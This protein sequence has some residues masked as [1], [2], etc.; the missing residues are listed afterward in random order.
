MTSFGE[1]RATLIRTA[2]AGE[3][4]TALCAL[5][6]SWLAERY[7]SEV[8]ECGLASNGEISQGVAL[9]AVGGYGRGELCPGS[10]IDLLLLHD[11][12]DTGSL[13]D[14]I[15]YPIWD[16]KL[17]LGHAVRSL[18]Q[19]LELAASDTDTATAIV[20]AR[21]LAGDESLTGRLISGVHTDWREHATQRLEA[22]Q[23]AV[24][25][26]HSRNG[27][28]AFLLE[29]DLKAGRGGLRD[30]HAIGWARLAGAELPAADTERLAD[31]YR[32]LLRVRTELHRT[33]GWRSDVLSAD[34]QDAV[35]ERLAFH[36]ADALMAEIAQAGR[37]VAFLSDQLWSSVTRRHVAHKGTVAPTTVSLD[38]ASPATFAGLSI[39]DGEVVIDGDPA[40]DTVL[41]LHAALH[42][43]RS[44]IPI[45]RSSLDKLAERQEW[46]ADPWP[47][48][49][50]DVLVDLLKCGHKAIS[51]IETLDYFDVWT[52]VLPE[53]APN[54]HRP[55][56]SR[57][58]RFTVDRHLL[59]A[60]AE[61]T[62]FVQQVARPD[63]LLMGALLHDIGKGYP[64]D[65]T[66]A[67]MRLAGPIM[68]RCGWSSEDA[69]TVVRLVQHHLLLTDVATRRDLDDPLTVATVA[70]AT[71]TTEFL[72]LLAAMTEADCV[73]T[74]PMAWSDWTQSLVSALAKLTAEHLRGVADQAPSSQP[75]SGQ[76][77]SG[78]PSSGQPSS[79]QPSSGQ[80]RSGHQRLLTEEVVKLM[81]AGETALLADHDVLTV[82]A[83]DERGLFSRAAG[84]LAL[85]GLDVLAADAYSSP[86]G[87]AVSSFRIVTPDTPVDWDR[88]RFDVR[89]SLRGHLALEARIA[90]R[91]RVYRRRRA[92]SA[93]R[94]TTSV[95]FDAESATEAT[96]V[97]IRTED[98]IG[99]LYKVTRVLAEMGLDIR[100][101]KIQTLANEVV[102]SFY[103]VGPDGPVLDPTHQREVELALR[104]A[105]N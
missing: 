84:V 92:L 65:H 72:E 21:H 91:A 31:A 6:D 30:A 95:K 24:S 59:E 101:A 58:H 52:R 67:G 35:A 71:Q 74:G 1:R 28:V 44:E 57:Y 46:F 83:P 5:T 97:E 63:L 27:E 49:A 98:H 53:W 20:D 10:D 42:S 19:T 13:A 34:D 40:V 7:V 75:S 55:Q 43:A 39:R 66:Q 17:K 70:R 94:A 33:T 37:I 45:S 4:P 64:G 76:P 87:M 86:E 73:A 25:R 96:I 54:R 90:E 69:D 99:V 80:P 15:W 2:D 41:V 68:R 85:R 78:Q 51:V 23:R 77:S 82:V 93:T 38:C 9:V 14:R 60:V 81:A 103:V 88:V 48:G 100:S 50:R 26:R 18:A 36:D 47:Q 11:D 8:A 12:V 62:R 102:D 32:K 105:L 104:H 29:P 56:R 22:L 61:A 89:R 3:L 79:G 16:A